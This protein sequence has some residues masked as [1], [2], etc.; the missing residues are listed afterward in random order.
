MKLSPTDITK[1]QKYLYRFFAERGRPHLPWRQDHDPYKVMVSE[2]MLQQ[3]QVDRVIPKFEAFLA[4]FPDV[5]ALAK[6]PVAEIITAWQGLGYNRRGLNLQR[7]AQKIISEFDGEFP[8]DDDS[9]L[10]LPGIGPY[11]AAAIRAFAFNQPSVV[12]ETNIRTVFIFHF[13]PAADSVKDQELITLIDQTMDRE[14]PRKWYSALM[15]YG[16]YLKQNTPNPTRRSSTYTKQSKLKG[17]NREVRGK[18]LKVLSRQVTAPAQ[19]LAKL[20]GI[21]EYRIEP[22]LQQLVKEGFLK[23]DGQVVKLAS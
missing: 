10:S 20:T 17:S 8:Q 1:F 16:S 21:A 4:K 18:I 11:T 23:Y 22:A 9:L 15:D 13:F 14:N 7:A 3:T 12:I 6:A 2:I 5:E 19:D